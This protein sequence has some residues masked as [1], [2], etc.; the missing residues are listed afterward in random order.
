ME[1]EP[2]GHRERLG[3]YIITATAGHDTTSNA[4]AGGLH[5][6]IENPSELARLQADPS[7]L[8]TAVDEMIRWT[9]PVK[10]F[11]RTA[12]CDYRVH[13]TTIKEGQDV[14]LSYWSANR[15]ED[16]VADTFRFDVGRTPNKHL[17]FGFGIHYCLGAM[18]ARMELMTSPDQDISAVVERA[19][20]AFNAGRTR[21][22]QWRR[23]TLLLLRELIASREE[24]LLQAVA[25]DF[26]KPRMEA[27]ATEVGFMQFDIDHVLTH[28]DSWMRPEKVPTPV[29]F[30]PG[31]SSI[32]SEP[33][34]VVCVIA[35]WNYPLQLLLVPMIAAIAAGNAVVGKPSELTP[36]CSAAMAKLVGRLG[37]PAVSV[38]EGGV[39]ETTELLTH[40]FDHILYTGNGRVGRVVMQAAVEHL[41]P[42]TLELGGKSPAIV[43][44]HAKIDMAAKRIVWGKFLN[45]G[46][47]C[48]APDYVLVERR[49]HDEFVRALSTSITEFYGSDPQRSPDLARIVNDAHFNRL[50][51][52]LHGGTI[53][54]GGQS[55]PATRFI[56]P[57]VLT[58]ITRDDAVMQE[59]IFG[60]ILPVIAVDSLDEAM[61]FVNTDDKPLALYT[62]SEQ[63]ED[64]DL[65]VAGTSSGGVCV[66]GTIMHISNPHLPFGGV[67][68]SGMGAYHGKFGFDTFSHRRG[69]HTRSTR[70]DPPILYPPYTTKKEALLRRGM[71]IPDPRDLA[72]KLTS[73]LRR[74]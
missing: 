30:Q 33:L 57:T 61:R 23:S 52:L 29:L 65:V 63:D 13:G 38:I 51:K 18:L 71:G 17:A 49:V 7:V 40:R 50:E 34:G 43:S 2:I 46:Q 37:E 47:T 26:G 1:G 19:R 74:R 67:G 12:T 54:V 32:V 22:M 70:I 10:H 27:F 69:V 56:A 36:H 64:N 8:A 55:D 16:V 20:D 66:N 31:S 21:S 68:G 35:P 44:R 39:P 48:I 45:A 15:D 42:V 24:E 41:T 3:Y 60:P 9:S 73:R 72:A 11:M 58:G 53:A 59:E 28:L 5:A 4:M 62:F 6:L 25:S 14:L